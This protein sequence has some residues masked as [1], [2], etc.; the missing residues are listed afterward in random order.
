[1][2]LHHYGK[3]SNFSQNFAGFQ[4]PFSLMNVAYAGSVREHFEFCLKCDKQ[5]K[6]AALSNHRIAH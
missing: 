3:R 1:M 4:L 2:Y 5:T 6:K